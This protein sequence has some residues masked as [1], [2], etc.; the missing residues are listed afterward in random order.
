ME[1]RVEIL[2]PVLKR[3]LKQRV[4]DWLR[5]MLSD[6]VKARDQNSAGEY[7]YVEMANEEAEMD[8]QYMF[9]KLSHNSVN[10]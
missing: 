10:D 2:F 1:N 7:Q 9:C 3:H 6:S 8:S 5:I 4:K